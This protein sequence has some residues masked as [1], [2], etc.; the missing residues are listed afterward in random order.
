[1][2]RPLKNGRVVVCAAVKWLPHDD[3]YILA[4]RALYSTK[5]TSFSNQLIEQPS[6]A[7]QFGGRVE[8]LHLAMVQHDNPITVEDGVDPMCNYCLS[9]MHSKDFEGCLT[10]NDSTILEHVTAQG[11]LQ[12]CICLDIDCCRSLIQDQNVA[13]C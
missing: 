9:V 13:R 4:L 5:Q 1:M 10:R 3:T 8:F 12:H 7:D 2:Q 6:S 11:C